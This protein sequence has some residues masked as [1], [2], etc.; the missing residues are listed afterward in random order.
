MT[1]RTRCKDCEYRYAVARSVRCKICQRKN[2][3]RTRH[4]AHLKATYGINITDY[5]RMLEL[6]DGGCAICGG[7]TS[8]N[9]LAVDHDHRSGEV[10]GL[11]DA[12]CNK[13]LGRFRDDPQ[14]FRNAA[15]YLDSPPA[16]KVLKKRDWSRFADHSKKS[17]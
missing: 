4:S 12:N 11:L 16:R 13:T 5:D 15:D 6:Q 7:G 1:S 17:K 2:A 3:R 14:R 9:F 10:R 8:K